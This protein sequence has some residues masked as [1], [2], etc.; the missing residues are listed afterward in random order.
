MDFWA[1]QDNVHDKVFATLDSAVT[2]DEQLT[3][4]IIK[5]QAVITI[6]LSHAFFVIY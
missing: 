6:T 3:V 1:L 2:L 4:I 5:T